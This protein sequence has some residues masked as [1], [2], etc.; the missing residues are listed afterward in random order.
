MPALIDC[1]LNFP[2]PNRRLILTRSWRRAYRNFVPDLFMET[3]SVVA[4]CR[5]T[6]IMFLMPSLCPRGCARLAPL[7]SPSSSR[8]CRI[9]SLLFALFSWCLA[10]LQAET[11]APASM[12]P[13]P[14]HIS[15]GWNIPSE[16]YADQPYIVQTDDGAWLCVITTGTGKEGDPGQH[17]VS[18]RS[19]DRGRTWDQIVPIEPINGPEASYVVALKV[20][21]GR[22]YAF[23]NHNTDRVPEVK[24]E[25][26]GAYKRVDSLGHYVFKFSDDHGRTWSPERYEIPIRDFESDR[27]KVY[28]G[29]LRFFWNVGRP[30]ILGDAAILVLHKVGAM[31]KGFFAESEGAFLKSKNLLTERNPEKI[32]FETLPDGDIG[33][34]TPPDGGRVAESKVSWHSVTAPFFVSTARSTAGRPL[35]TVATVAIAGPRR[36]IWSTLRTA[37]V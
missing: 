19:T 2:V 21:G 20:P 8:R 27:K 37:G 13:D 28:G 16:G 26:G 1:G 24:R 11:S 32:T 25:D 6:S 22:I 30:L 14:R 34:R 18:M 10:S 12:I 17:V 3:M 4:S 36:L 29:K 15:N 23:Y 9:G 33:L 31:G 35:R 7:F 5:Y